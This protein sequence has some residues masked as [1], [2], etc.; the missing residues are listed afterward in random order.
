MEQ[1]YSYNDNCFEVFLDDKVVLD[2]TDLLNKTLNYLKRQGKKV[3]LK[4]FDS[5]KTPIVEIDGSKY[6]F[7]KVVGHIEGARFI[8]ELD[9]K[10][11]IQNEDEAIY[12]IESKDGY[13]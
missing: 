2:V 13:I 10:N 1:I 9:E 11:E 6:T 4:G 8:K 3:A 12:E 7:K 5:Y